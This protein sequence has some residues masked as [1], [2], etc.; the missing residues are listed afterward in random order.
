MAPPSPAT[1][2]QAPQRKPDYGNRDAIMT[3]IARV[4]RD[5]DGNT[6][7]TERRKMDMKNLLMNRGG[8]DNQ[9]LVW[10]RDQW[11]RRPFDGDLG[12]PAWIPRIA[13]NHFS[14]KVEGVASLLTQSDPA[15]QCVPQ[16]DS[17]R[18][19]AAAEVAENALPVLEEEIGYPRM[20][21]ELNE[22][23]TLTSTV[24]VHYYYDA[25]DKHGVGTLPGYV[26]VNPECPGA[27]QLYD[28]TEVE[29]VDLVDPGALPEDPN[30]GEP[31]RGQ[32]CP[33]C[34]A[35]V[36][37]MP[38][39]IERPIGRIAA[40][41]LSTFEHTLPSSA[42]TTDTQKLPWVWMHSTADENIVCGKSGEARHLARQMQRLASPFSASAKSG[43]GGTSQNAGLMVYRLQ[44]D[45]VVDDE[46]NFPDGLYC[47]LC[48]D[49]LLLEDGPLPLLDPLTQ[50]RRK[51]VL[52]RTYRP[53]PGTCF[54]KPVAD[55]LCPL[56]EQRNHYEMLG[57]MILMHHA[58]PR[59]YIP[60]DV[61]L[62]D[63]LSGVPG[64]TV[65]F[66][67]MSGTTSP[68]TVPGQNIPP[69]LP[70]MIEAVDKSMEE[71]SGLNAVL[72]GARPEGDPTLGEVEILQ[73]RGMSAMRSP[74]AEQVE[75][76]RQQARILLDIGR[77]SAWSPRFRRIQGENKQWQLKAFT[78]MDLA[79]NI[80]IVIDPMSAWPKSPLMEQMRLDK[81]VELGAIVPAQDPEVALKVV[82][83]LGLGE[84]KP[85][86]DEDRMQVARELDR[87]RAAKTP[88]E[89]LPPE[90]PA[91][92]MGVHLVL[93][94]GFLKTEEAEAV[95]YSNPVLWQAWVAHVQ[96]LEMAMA[97]P[98]M[99]GPGGGPAPAG[100]EPPTTHA[101]D[102]AVQAGVLT[103]AD[104]GG[105]ALGEA[106][107]GGVLVEEGAAMQQQQAAGPSIDELTAA[108]VLTP[109]PFNE[110]VQP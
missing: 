53:M 90:L 55:D 78:G 95:K 46:V 100:E 91:I 76:E 99:A 101:V 106:V 25:S 10:E 16:T 52:V 57:F 77:Q 45:P 35:P 47:V 15:K 105:D 84:L 18:D 73:E 110:G 38:D 49:D 20:R 82:Q 31:M 9:H 75:F 65:R 2:A 3:L 27:G 58:S 89:I 85:S 17:D 19:M 63:E 64:Q 41:V 71:I 32:G 68:V 72:G 5:V 83:R 14:K 67:S 96:Q 109:L 21:A 8:P 70:L 98:P 86:L 28:A 107:A 29:D 103:P 43:G 7:V 93:K 56:Q 39:A 60:A 54:G 81:A 88:D 22:H 6:A 104:Q 97:P 44:H 42:K 26:C 108:N 23:I 50:K 59:T 94:K 12:L 66:T 69:T 40:E 79:G 51:S 92:N 24:A 74:L 87:W 37:E 61:T 34:G 102:A 30:A 36:E 33:E 13:T 1:E 80:D 11:V 62:I 48:G 4:R